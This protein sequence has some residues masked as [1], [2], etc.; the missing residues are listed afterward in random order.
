MRINEAGL[1]II[2]QFE[3]CKLTTYKDMVGINTI[4]YGHTGDVATPGNTIDQDT[5]D[6]LLVE[7]VEK[8]EAGVSKLISKIDITD[9][10]F[11]ALVAFAY[12]VGVH[13]LAQSHLLIKLKSGD[14]AGAADAFL[15]WDRA[16]GS[17]VPGLLRR[18]T[19]ERVLFKT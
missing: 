1:D 12:N 4:G 3:S 19:A 8:T 17:V 9:N 14:I 18:R 7:D 10:Q 11:S 6:Q 15:I 13:A 16:A 2:K 5:A